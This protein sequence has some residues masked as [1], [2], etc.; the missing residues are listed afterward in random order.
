M[1][2]INEIAVNDTR[3]C[4]LLLHEV[5]IVD[6]MAA[7]EGLFMCDVVCLMYDSTDADSFQP[8]VEAYRRFV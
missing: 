2:S 1:I 3:S 5:D 8:C 7:G 4:Y 6:L